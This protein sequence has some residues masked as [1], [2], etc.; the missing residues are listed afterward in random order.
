MEYIYT[1]YLEFFSQDGHYAN[2]EMKFI[3]DKELEIKLKINEGIY[4]YTGNEL[5]FM[6][7]GKFSNINTNIIKG[8]HEQNQP[9]IEKVIINV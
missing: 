2:K 6:F 8:T 1:V 4:I 5:V 3:S 9:L 7:H